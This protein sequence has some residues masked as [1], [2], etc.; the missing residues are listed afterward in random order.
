MTTE[1][2]DRTCRGARGLRRGAEPAMAEVLI[3]TQVRRTPIT[4]AA[5]TAIDSATSTRIT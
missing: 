2:V 4:V 3:T 5:S 1:L